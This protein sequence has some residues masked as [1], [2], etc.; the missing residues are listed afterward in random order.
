LIIKQWRENE[1]AKMNQQTG[2]ITETAN[3]NTTEEQI[4]IKT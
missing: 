1:L 2:S 3:G 4:I